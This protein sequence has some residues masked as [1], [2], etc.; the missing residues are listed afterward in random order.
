MKTIVALICARG[1]S[2]GI[3]NKNL[4]KIDGKSLL[5]I[6]IEHAKKINKIKK[7]F[8]STDSKKIAKEAIKCGAIVPFIRPK[9]L[10]GDKVPEILVWRHA[11]NFL[12][13]KLKINPDC[14]VSLPVTSPLREIRDIKLGIK[15]FLQK[16]LDILF[17]VTKSHRN[18]YFNIVQKKKNKIQ[19]VINKKKNFHRR[20]D[21]PSCYDLCTVCYV[22]KPK[23]ILKNKNLFSGKTDFF[24]VSKRSSIDIDTKFDYS[25]AKILYKKNE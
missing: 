1:G 21:A 19:T 2:K 10:A 25:I 14:I 23:Y 16:K 18:P 20:Q 15:K 22:F 24:E 6:S 8:V 12:S 3:K 5:R 7:I 13:K 9:K 11:V 4:L 17:T